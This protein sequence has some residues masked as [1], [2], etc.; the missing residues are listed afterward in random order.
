[1]FLEI[2]L[3]CTRSFMR[4]LQ[5]VQ[6]PDVKID[7]IIQQ[8]ACY[9]AMGKAISSSNSYNQ[10]FEGWYKE[11]LMGILGCPCSPGSLGD[12]I[13]VARATL[14]VG[15][16]FSA[17]SLELWRDALSR[18]VQNLHHSDTVIKL[19]SIVALSMVLFELLS[20]L[21]VRPKPYKTT[22]WQIQGFRGGLT[23]NFESGT[24]DRCLEIRVLEQGMHSSV[25]NICLVSFCTIIFRSK[26]Y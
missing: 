24:C 2:F 23:G 20:E 4:A 15:S 1:M 11:E 5:V 12:R 3:L 6:N 13:L 8:E 16:C 9:A 10:V 25:A 26:I 17:L 19:T 7:V 18:L 14:L 21:E 22:T